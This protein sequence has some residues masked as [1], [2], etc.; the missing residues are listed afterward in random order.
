MIRKLLIICMA[1][2]LFAVT[3]S[4]SELVQEQADMFGVEAVEKALT[5]DSKELMRGYDP[6][7]QTDFLQGTFSV[8]Q[9]ALDIG[10][11]K[12]QGALGTMLRIIAIVILCRIADSVCSERGKAITS[13][14]GTVAIVVSSIG[15]VN[16]MVGLGRTTMNE[17]LSFSNTLLPVMVSAATATGSVSGA[18]AVYTLATV[19]SNFLIRF[20]NYILLPAIYSY[21][22][23]ALADAVTQQDRLKI[24]RELIGW[25][26]EKGLKLIVFVFTGF[27]TI[28]GLLAESAD[29]VLIKAAKATIS[30]VVPVVGNMITGA[31][32]SILSTAAL[33]KNTIGVFGMMAIFSIF[34]VPFL[35]MTVSYLTFKLSS[36]LC[37]IISD[38]HS[39]ILEAISN[40]MGYMLAMVGS[41]A[42]ICTLS[43][44]FLAKVV[45]V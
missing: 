41:C 43:C 24:L 16:A 20:T 12:V 21:I 15:R 19:F 36:A 11:G 9:K 26:I 29:T 34:V 14:T 2:Y 1:V 18:G 33:L 22:T 39:G 37:G 25:L 13:V 30:G 10:F 38:K 5:G 28:T 4:A 6:L 3:A 42:L 31:A 44:C 23:L 45:G 17:L 32:G 7:T 27:L 35:N 8:F 40:A